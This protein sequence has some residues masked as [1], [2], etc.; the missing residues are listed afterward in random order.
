MTL[1]FVPLKFITA[2]LTTTFFAASAFAQ[3]TPIPKGDAN[4]HAGHDRI[5]VTGSP[6]NGPA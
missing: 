5:A 1:K 4:P 3:S 2:L 6:M